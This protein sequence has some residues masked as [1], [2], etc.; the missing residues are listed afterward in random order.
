MKTWVKVL[1]GLIILGVLGGIAGYVFI[2]NKPHPDYEKKKPDYAM[3]ATGLFEAYRN[4][5]QEASEKYNGKV[6]EVSGFLTAVE[7]SGEMVIAIFGLDEGMFGVEGVRVT[8]LPNHHNAVKN[9]DMSEQITLK[10]VCTGFND[11]DVI[12]EKGSVVN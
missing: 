6:L 8:M 7:T 9:Y 2:Y 1:I 4:D 10:G 12:I 11:P 3:T 5:T